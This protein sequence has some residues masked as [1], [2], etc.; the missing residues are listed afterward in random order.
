MRNTKS[1]TSE[2]GT[3]WVRLRTGREV[4]I[5]NAVLEEAATDYLAMRLELGSGDSLGVANWL[6]ARISEE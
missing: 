6:R 3:G 4:A 5:R 1:N 2:R